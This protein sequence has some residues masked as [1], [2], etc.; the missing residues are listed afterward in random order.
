MKNTNKCTF[1]YHTLGKQSLLCVLHFSDLA[2]TQSKKIVRE[3]HLAPLSLQNPA[4]DSSYLHKARMGG[5]AQGPA[6]VTTFPQLLHVLS[7]FRARECTHQEEEIRSAHRKA[8]VVVGGGAAA[9]LGIRG[10]GWGGWGACVLP[11][12]ILRVH[13]SARKARPAW[14]VP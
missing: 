6:F 9:S 12:G 7:E 8:P 5:P 14:Q 4:K 2:I 3:C 10:P 13:L 1:K 11:Q